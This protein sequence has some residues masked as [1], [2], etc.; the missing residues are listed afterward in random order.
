[1]KKKD[2]LKNPV[3]HVDITVVRRH[4][5]HR[6]HARDVLHLA[7]HRRRGRHLRPHAAA[8]RAAPSC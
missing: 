7:G 4:P 6:R 2:L 8:T 3:R 1:M 5:H